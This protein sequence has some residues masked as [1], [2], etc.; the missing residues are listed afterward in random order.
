MNEYLEL[1]I[2]NPGEVYACLG[3]LEILDK[4]SPGALGRFHDE[5]F[6]VVAD[7]SLCQVVNQVKQ[8]ALEPEDTVTSGTRWR[9][10]S[11]QPVLIRTDFGTLPIESWLS[12]DHSDHDKG[13]KLWAGRVQTLNLLEKLQQGLPLIETK[14]VRGL[15]NIGRACTP[16][17]LDPRSAISRGDLGFSYDSHSLKPIV[18]P[19]VDLFAMMGFQVARPKRTGGTTYAYSLWEKLLLP[20]LAARAVISCELPSMSMSRWEYSIES[21]GLGGTYRNLSFAKQIEAT[22]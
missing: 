19:A 9:E 21:R 14:D 20:P 16:T 5:V 3:L 17:G 18:Y 13:L 4:I 15:F 1:D 2:T 11:T 8:A 6:E 22:S 12:P 7:T 10:K